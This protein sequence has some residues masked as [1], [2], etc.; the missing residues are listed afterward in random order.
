MSRG[1]P[2]DL[3]ETIEL[4]NKPRTF[5]GKNWL[6]HDTGKQCGRIDE[7]L[8]IGSTI[9]EI[10]KDLINKGLSKRDIKTT[11]ARVN[12]HLDHLVKEEHKLPIKENKNGVW[13]FSISGGKLGG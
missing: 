12:R 4:I 10:A 1:R 9:E 11:K 6:G 2:S 3:N 13:K 8:L 5:H 7:L